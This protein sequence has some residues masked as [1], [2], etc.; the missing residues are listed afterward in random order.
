MGR[1]YKYGDLVLISDHLNYDVG[2]QRQ[3][4]IVM[5]EY[6]YTECMKQ[7]TTL[8]LCIKSMKS[9]II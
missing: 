6:G 5:D 2:Y 1:K 4:W 9:L 3:I 8:K 7:F